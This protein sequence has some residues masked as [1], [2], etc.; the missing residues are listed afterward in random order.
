MSGAT[1]LR[2]S[3]R[4]FLA[5]LGAVAAGLTLT[6]SDGESAEAP[7]LNFYNWDT[8]IGETTLADF[9]KASG[10]KVKMDLYADNDE[11]FAKLKEGNPGYDVIIPSDTYVERMAIA[12]MIVALD[13]AQIPNIKNL[14]STFLTAAFDPGRKYSLPYMWGTIG[15]GYRKSKVEPAPDSWKWFYD[16]DRYSG[17]IALLGDG[18]TV[19]GMGLKYLGESLNATN[20]KLIKAVEEMVIRQK[21]HIKVFAEDNGQDL[22]ASGE[23]DLA[24]EWN[25]DILQVMTEDSDIGYTVPREGGLVWED[26]IAIP[27]GAPHPNNAHEFINYLLEPEPA[28]L[29]A[30]FIQYATPNREAKKHLTKDYLSNPAVFPPDRVIKVSEAAKYLG[31]DHQRLIEDTWTRIQAA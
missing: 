30:Q 18:S 31:E 26:A 19:V 9:T 11:L 5:G 10:I 12:G 16:S 4:S 21:P 15:I 23:V 14:E 25:G 22:L 7:K 8:Y 17:R 20:P 2:H 24:M 6:P 28:A 27:T 13:H 3:R 1:R 29:I